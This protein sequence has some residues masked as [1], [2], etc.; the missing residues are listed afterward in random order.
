[1]TL[2]TKYQRLTKIRT[3]SL[4]LLLS[5]IFPLQGQESALQTETTETPEAVANTSNLFLNDITYSKLASFPR[6]K[7][8]SFFF[9]LKKEN[10]RLA[11]L[12]ENA[13]QSKAEIEANAEALASKIEALETGKT[14]ANEK[15]SELTESLAALE[16]QVSALKEEVS[17]QPNPEEAVKAALETASQTWAQEKSKFEK[18]LADTLESL[19]S[20]QASLT[21]L[22]ETH[23]SEIQT[24]SEEHAAEK[25]ALS[26]KVD[27]LKQALEL[28][29]AEEP[30]VAQ[31]S[32]N[33]SYLVY[34]LVAV[35]IILLLGAGFFLKHSQL[36]KFSQEIEKAKGK[37][38]QLRKEIDARGQI[39]E[40][41]NEKLNGQVDASNKNK[42]QV[43][44]ALAQTKAAEE[45]AKKL[46][47]ELE[48]KKQSI[49]RLTQER[50][51]KEQD[52]EKLQ[53]Q[54]VAHTN[55]VDDLT[56][57][58]K[59]VEGE[60]E[61]NRE[62]T[63]ELETQ[64]QEAL[65]LA[66]AEKAE[67]ETTD[68]SEYT[69]PLQKEIDELKHQLNKKEQDCHFL[70]DQIDELKEE[71]EE[72][73]DGS[74]TS[75]ANKQDDEGEIDE[76]IEALSESLQQAESESEIQEQTIAELNKELAAT[77]KE[78]ELFREKLERFEVEIEA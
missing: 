1:M 12:A 31:A 48:Q 58:L 42:Q 46:K 37:Q 7:I 25:K 11:E 8:L 45:S 70:E 72:L 9:D 16:S 3:L 6:K 22:S 60:A 21:A 13:E 29:R 54:L 50:D 59:S 24:V 18:E 67:P 75:G 62:K 69:G 39:V 15:N 74:A 63:Q 33:E 32:G 28:A 4:F 2:G 14:Q 23:Q 57:K 5:A 66:T 27:S 65:E 55:Q 44:E 30:Q 47:D 51:D 34:L 71:I 43:E 19:E 36:S 41:L 78:N 35:G 64:L 53:V 49:S 73:S 10:S 17:Q 56:L 40:S 77:R 52:I 76:K 20:T 61:T 38:E 68:V 26:K